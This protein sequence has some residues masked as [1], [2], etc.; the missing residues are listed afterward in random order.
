MRVRNKVY[1]W[2]RAVVAGRALKPYVGAVN[3]LMSQG[4]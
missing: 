1:R 2:M 3:E 4:K